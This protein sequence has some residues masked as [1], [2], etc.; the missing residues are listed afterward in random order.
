MNVSILKITSLLI[1][2]ELLGITRIQAQNKVETE[3]SL[4]LLLE[5]AQV[6]SLQLEILTQ[7]AILHGSTDREKSIGYYLQA[8]NHDM[9]DDRK[10]RYLNTVGF[11]YWNLG[12]FDEAIGFYNQ[13][14][15]IFVELNDSLQIG[16]VYNN[17][18]TSYWALGKWNDALQTYQIGFKI[19][20]AANDLKGV[21][22]ILNNIGLIYQDF[23]IYDEALDYHNEALDIALDINS[24]ESITYSYSN[25]GNCY[26]MKKE[27]GPALEYHK[28]GYKIYNENVINGISNSYFQ[29]NIGV[30]YRELE[31]FDSALY[32]F[33]LSLEGAKLIHNEHRVAIAENNLG[34]TYLLLDDIETAARFINNSYR[35][36]IDNNYHYLLRDNEFALSKIE[37]AKGR[38]DLAFGHF[39]KAITLRDSLFNKEEISKFTELTIRQVKEKE[40]N[41]KSLLKENIEIQK[42]IIREERIILWLLI[43]GG[44]LLIVALIY[45]ERSR[46][47]IKKL[48]SKLRNSEK[49]LNQSNTDKDKFFSIISHDLRSPFNAII[50]L[51]HLL[52]EEV[53][54][55]NIENIEM[56]SNT[57]H[58]SS[59]K[60]MDLLSNLMEW[61]LSQTGRMNFTPEKTDINVV[62]NENVLF[63][64]EIAKQKLISITNKTPVSTFVD[65]DKA[66]INTVLR[67]FIS[68]AIK[69]SENGGTIEISTEIKEKTVQISVRDT[70]VGL[71]KKSIEK[72]F[73]TDIQY[74]TYGTQNEKGTGLGLILCKEFIEKHQGEIGVSSELDTGSIFYFTLPYNNS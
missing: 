6:D 18:A 15:T 67:N 73:Q 46:K 10:A 36:A 38:L 65:A 66:M 4:M 13:S 20:K 30:V 24:F 25:I 62:I 43:A 63:F 2:F 51:T 39:K 9:D 53:K 42:A 64:I 37:E 74:S 12:K 61:S 56:Y 21:S 41:E 50:G 26:A 29:S 57:I 72:I 33:N 68:N 11:Y 60:A 58:N 34:K 35:H 28:L 31:K 47:S 71:S 44:L 70:G 52:T 69:F 14:L 17:I 8:L 54:E 27:F 22:T 48:N 59:Q 45:I 16:R 3:D 55:K 1:I 7:L 32:Y 40:E 23:G 5:Q 49:G 19:R